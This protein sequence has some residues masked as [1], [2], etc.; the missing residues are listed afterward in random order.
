MAQERRREEALR[1]ALK[2]L[3]TFSGKSAENVYDFISTIDD[4][5]QDYELTDEEGG[6]HA[7]NATGSEARGL[8]ARSKLKGWRAIKACLID[9]YGVG[10]EETVSEFNHCVQG[11]NESVGDYAHRLKGLGER[12]LQARLRG[13]AGTDIAAMREMQEESLIHN[14]KAGLHSYLQD[15][16]QTAQDSNLSGTRIRFESIKQCA[17]RQ[18]N[19]SRKDKR[20]H[21]YAVGVGGQPAAA[22]VAQLAQVAHAAPAAKQ[23]PPAAPNPAPVVVGGT[24]P[25][26]GGQPGR[27]QDRYP[28]YDVVCWGCNNVGHVRSNCPQQRAKGGKPPFGP[29][30]CP[31]C[32]QEGHRVAQCPLQ[33][34]MAAAYT[35]KLQEQAAQQQAGQPQ[36][37]FQPSAP[38]PV[39][40]AAPAMSHPNA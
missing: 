29:P 37:Q 27:K 1:M 10:T 16:V 23:A 11:K 13:R 3:P 32:K 9:R 20:M 35:Q 28:G 5:V 25:Q 18:E 4:V 26:P 14:F 2:G 24:A 17:V 12:A 31:V 15:A 8:I 21:V 38:A 40:A 30:R 36:A 34:A 7:K 6:R 39:P 19:K 22:P 33:Q